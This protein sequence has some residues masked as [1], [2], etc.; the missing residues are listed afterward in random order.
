[1]VFV[2]GATGLVGSYLLL[3]LSRRGETIRALKRESSAIESVEQLFRDFDLTEKFEQIEWVVADLLDVTVLSD[4]LKDVK[5]IYH[6]AAVVSFD[7]KMKNQLHE[8]NVIG[9]KNL[10]NAAISEKIPEFVFFSSI[11]ALDAAPNEKKINEKS[12]WNAELNHSPYA[13]AKRKSEME[14]WRGS[15]EGLKVLV[16]YPGIIIG[17]L[18]GKRESERIFRWANKKKVWGP[19]GVTAYIDVRDVAF[20]TVE[21]AKKEKWDEGFL[22]F[23]GHQSYFGIFQILRKEWKMSEPKLLSA[24]ILNFIQRISSFLRY[25]GLPHLSRTNY[26]ALISSSVYSNEKLNHEIPVNL[27]SIEDALIF[28]GN[29]FQKNNYN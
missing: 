23:S 5:T 11:A 17:S 13:I 18:D 4:V 21:L 3:E 24:F 15:Q 7:K 8:I 29:R 19:S 14:V 16:L 27:H 10:V 6:A 25:V 28:H 22:L 26:R 1:M 12:N 9:T 2:T 20:C